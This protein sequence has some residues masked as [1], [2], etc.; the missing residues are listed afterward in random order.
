MQISGLV[1]ASLLPLIVL[2]GVMMAAGGGWFLAYGVWVPLWPGILFFGLSF[3]LFPLLLIPAAM[4][5]GI[6]TAFAQSNKTLAKVCGL[7]SMGWIVLLFSLHAAAIF[8]L[9]GDFAATPLLWGMTLWAAGVTVTPWAVFAWKDRDNILFTG[10]V[11][12][13]LAACLLTGGLYVAGAG[14]SFG[15]TFLTIGAVMVLLLSLQ[16]LYEKIFLK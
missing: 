11:L 2:G 13:L 12:M 8:A 16:G 10:L 7:L 3:F 1:K 14:M 15:L 6:M 4:F 5:A 9:V